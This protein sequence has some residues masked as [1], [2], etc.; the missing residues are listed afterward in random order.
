MNPIDFVNPFICTQGD[1]GQL[2]PGATCPFGAVKLSP[3]TYP[4][5][6]NGDAHAGYDFA[7]NRVLGFT[8][9]RVGGMGCNGEGG[10]ILLLPVIGDVEFEA[11]KYHQ[12]I[13]KSS[14]KA[15]PGYYAVEFENQ[16]QAELTVTEH[17]GLHKYTFPKSE[18]ARILIDLGRTFTEMMNAKLEIV[19]PN[20]VQGQLTA[21]HNCS[22]ID[23]YTLYFWAT[24]SKPFQSFSTWNEKNSHSESKTQSGNNIGHFGHAWRL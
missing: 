7:D 9:V 14:E 16:I 21:T 1:H 24:F 11:E 20:A 13:I 3:D 6:F 18:G 4:H 8:H 17:A 19:A 10:N 12:G 5:G 23:T 15:S 2:Y 22:R